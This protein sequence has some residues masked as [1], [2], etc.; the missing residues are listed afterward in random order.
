MKP[1][2][3]SLFLFVLPVINSTVLKLNNRLLK[4]D[5]IVFYFGLVV[6]VILGAIV[7]YSFI[8][9]VHKDEMDRS[10]IRLIIELGKKSIIQL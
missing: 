7:I 5:R 9:G 6:F 3:L 2:T 4:C 8:S 1:L 10:L